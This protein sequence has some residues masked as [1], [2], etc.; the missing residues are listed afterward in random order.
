MQQGRVLLEADWNEAQ[1]IAAEQLRTETRELIGP[2]GTPDDGYRVYAESSARRVIVRGGTMYV[3]GV[4]VTLPRFIIREPTDPIGTE[5]TN[6]PDWIDPPDGDPTAAFEMVW[7][8]LVEQEVSAVEDPALRDPAL[9]GPDTAQRTRILQ[10]IHRMKSSTADCDA[11]FAELQQTWSAQGWQYDPNTKRLQTNAALFAQ[12]HADPNAATPCDPV[13]Q[14]GFL[15]PEN[16][17]LR[18]AITSGNQFAWA[19]DDAS[20]LYRVDD[21]RTPQNNQ[22]FLTSRPVD[23]DHRPR[24]GQFVELLRATAYLPGGGAV[25]EP[26]GP[27]LAISGYDADGN[28]ITVNGP[29]PPGYDTLSRSGPVTVTATASTSA[30]AGSETARSAV[31][32]GAGSSSAAPRP[33]F[34]RI[35][36]RQLP[37]VPAAV[38][39]DTGATGV[40]TGVDVIVGAGA[41]TPPGD[42][43]TFAL[44]PSTPTV[45]YPARYSQSSQPPEGFRRWA[46]PLGVVD[47]NGAGVADCR[48]TFENLVALSKRTGCCIRVRPEDLT[49]RSLQQIIDTSPGG[50]TFCLGPGD[51]PLPAPLVLTQGHGAITIEGCGEGAVLH[52][53]MYNPTPIAFLSGLV[54]LQETVGVT[55]RRLEFRPGLPPLFFPVPLPTP[56]PIGGI[57]VGPPGAG[58]VAATALVGG[59]EVGRIGVGGGIGIPVGGG[60]ITIGPGPGLPPQIEIDISISLRIVDASDLTVEDCRFTFPPFPTAFAAD[61][62][63]CGAAIVANGVLSDVR[64]RRNRFEGDATRD[65]ELAGVVVTPALFHDTAG[66]HSLPAAVDHLCIDENDFFGLARAVWICATLRGASVRGNVV[67]ECTHGIVL[68]SSHWFGPIAATDATSIT[69]DL[70][71]ALTTDVTTIRTPQLPDSAAAV[72]AFCLAAHAAFHPSVAVPLGAYAMLPFPAGALGGGTVSPGTPPT[73]H[74]LVDRVSGLVPLVQP[75][76]FQLFTETDVAAEL[77]RL[78]GTP[79]PLLPLTAGIRTLDLSAYFSAAVVHATVEVSQNKVTRSAGTPRAAGLAF[80]TIGDDGVRPRIVN[81]GPDPFPLPPPLPITG[82]AADAELATARTIAGST[83]PGPDLT[84]NSTVVSANDFRTAHTFFPA[85]AMLF[86]HRCSITGNLVQNQ[87]TA[88][89]PHFVPSLLLVAVPDIVQPPA[90]SV[91]RPGGTDPLPVPSPNIGPLP[92]ANS[93]ALAGNA[94]SATSLPVDPRAPFGAVASG[95]ALRTVVDVGDVAPAREGFT[96]GTTAPPPPTIGAAITGN[97]LVGWPVLPIHTNRFLTAPPWWDLNQVVD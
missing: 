42:F 97:V 44:R 20:A 10:R 96:F 67:E 38:S 73:N 43:W 9:G 93:T 57:V 79:H 16:Q 62:R 47:W 33:L 18:V 65:T 19:F 21:G 92:S 56:I 91:L 87:A 24:A 95:D 66:R 23:D 3:G 31:V 78:W 82:F 69:T 63:P 27:F 81:P 72:S 15:G 76:H 64:I 59:T 1:E 2:T 22:L 48:E 75:F 89:D 28:F 88:V 70:T 45:I 12:F 74:S 46:C 60:G 83:V 53:A 8:E 49:K 25:A 71:P 86:E 61:A 90:F 52:P 54:R 11:A 50:S 7:L 37:I 80:L 4:R 51:Y 84:V 85:A 5:Y 55:L 94:A 32:F 36:E 39:L 29:L 17:F 6:Q 40:L 77:Q 68:I 30:Q 14:P 35:W 41:N 34:V 26:Y 13:S 58:G